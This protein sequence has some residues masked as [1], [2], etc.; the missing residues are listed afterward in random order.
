MIERSGRLRGRWWRHRAR[1]LAC[2]LACGCAS[3]PVVPPS[4]TTRVDLG[5]GNYRVVRTDVVGRSYGFSLLGIIPIV[6]PTYT[7]A[8]S[9]LTAHAELAQGRPQALVNVVQDRSTVYLV[10]FSVPKLTIRADVIE[11][12]AP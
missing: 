4:T 5:R 11:F 8:M 2:L 3:R 10:L 1:V 7:A 12:T 9:D 6:P